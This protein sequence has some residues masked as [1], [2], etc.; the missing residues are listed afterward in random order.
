MSGSFPVWIFVVFEVFISYHP[1]VSFTEM[2]ACISRAAGGMESTHLP[3]PALPWGLYLGSGMA[4]TG[5]CARRGSRLCTVGGRDRWE[6]GLGGVTSWGAFE[7]VL[8][9]SLLPSVG[10]QE[11]GRA[12]PGAPTTVRCLPTGP[13]ATGPAGHGLEPQS[14]EPADL[15]S[16]ELTSPG[17]LS[18]EG[19]LADMFC[20]V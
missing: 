7:G 9:A 8:G 16:C 20:V 6:A 10:G 14:R 1:E 18:T 17:V 3:L 5:P 2:S 13:K 12:L 15:P 19:R 11:S 4:S